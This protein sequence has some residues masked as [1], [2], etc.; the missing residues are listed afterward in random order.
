M[1]QPKATRTHAPPR[2]GLERLLRK[3]KT[4]TYA[5]VVLLLYLLAATALGLALAPSL[6]MAKVLFG[7]A[8]RLPVVLGWLLRG[9]ALAL[10]WFVSG[11]TL[12]VVVALYNKVLPTRL[13]SFKG[14]YYTLE[15]IPWFLHNG[16]FYLA[17]FTFMPFVTL[18]P[19]GIWFLKAM[20]MKI[21]KR[22]FINTEYLSDLALITV[23]DDAVIGG[24]ARICAHY[25]GGGS[26]VVAP[27]V[28]GDRATLGLACCIMGDV[29]IGEDATILPESVVLP[30]SRVGPGE[31]WGGVPARPI[32]REEMEAI[33]RLIRG[34]SGT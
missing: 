33:K 12:L 4:L 30:G 5:G 22:V 11:L 18:T 6:A 14:S 3:Y 9:F 25:G 17:R 20:G 16:L 29:L 19:Y 26:L 27:V 28:I 13:R 15:A 7:W 32:P 34:E 31:T 10:G 24:S 8:A 23:G 1:P 21:G 2:N